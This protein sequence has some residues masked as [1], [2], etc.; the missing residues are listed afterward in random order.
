MVHAR[1]TGLIPG[2]GRFPG[3]GNGSLFQYSYLENPMERGHK[4]SDTSEQLNNNSN[5]ICLY[6]YM[7]PVRFVSLENPDSHSFILSSSSSP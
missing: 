1:D 7:S 2:S 3:K 4:E 5:K 6:L